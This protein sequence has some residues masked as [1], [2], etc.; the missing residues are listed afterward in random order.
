MNTTSSSPNI[1]ELPS[2]EEL[3]NSCSILFHHLQKLFKLN[4]YSITKVWQDIHLIVQLQD[5]KYVHI[6]TWIQHMFDCDEH[7]QLVRSGQIFIWGY[8]RDAENPTFRISPE[9]G[10]EALNF[11]IPFFHYGWFEN[12]ARVIFQSIQHQQPSYFPEESIIQETKQAL[13]NTLNRK[14][15]TE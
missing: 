8:I 2:K 7:K 13:D 14:R 5:G 15:S 3:R 1:W 9:D 4:V 6:R 12:D 10:E 11:G